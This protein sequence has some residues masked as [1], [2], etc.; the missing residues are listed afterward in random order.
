MPSP[1]LSSMIFFFFFLAL[2]IE[3][4]VVVFLLG[5]ARCVCQID[6]GVRRGRERNMILFKF[7]FFSSKVEYL[8]LH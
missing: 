3:L 1:S 2:G 7:T 5:E 6:G 8:Q 4:R